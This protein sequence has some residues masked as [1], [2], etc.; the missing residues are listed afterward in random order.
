[1]LLSTTDVYA[2]AKTREP[3]RETHEVKPVNLYGKM[4]LESEEALLAA[5]KKS[6][7][8]PVIMRVAPVYKSSYT[9][10]LRDRVYD[11]KEDVGFVY[12][13]G[14]Y[15]FS[16]CCI[17]NLAE[18]VNGIL[19]GPQGHYDG[20]Y[21]IC[22]SKMTTAREI[23]EYERSFH[24][25]SGVV[26]RNANSDSLKAALALNGS[27]KSKADYRYVDLTT[28]TNNISYDN[29]KAQRISTFRWKLGNTK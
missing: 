24:R 16:F 4:K 13:E 11:N 26:Q 7:A 8:T 3:I 2:P 28:I 29:T 23:L 9:Q 10:N 20:E 27:K 25:I 17:Y 6:S 1:L 14:E 19:N 21:N 18:F 22:D 12:R 5:T 15:G